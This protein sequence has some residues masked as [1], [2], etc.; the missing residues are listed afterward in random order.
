MKQYKIRVSRDSGKPYEIAGTL[1]ELI[2]KFSYTLE[3]GKSWER[4]RGN[5]KINLTPKTARSLVTNLQNA[6]DNAAANGYSGVHYE[7]VN[8]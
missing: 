8:A 2:E 7:L 5:R 6:S 4:E 3:K 1:E